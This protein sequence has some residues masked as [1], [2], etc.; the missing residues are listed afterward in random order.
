MKYNEIRWNS[1]EIQWLVMKYN[2]TQW[3]SN[4]MQR[5]TMK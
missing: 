2:E 4:E 1:N 3:N 5:D